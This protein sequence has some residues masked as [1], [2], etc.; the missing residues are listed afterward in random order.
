MTRRDKFHLLYAI[1]ILQIPINLTLYL[2]FE[3]HLCAYLA[4]YGGVPAVLIAV[5][6][7]LDP[8]RDKH[9]CIICGERH[10]TSRA[11][12]EC[13]YTHADSKMGGA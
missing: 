8:T 2:T 7:V 6:G 1:S 10:L 12:E 4:L 5:T 3:W 13:G 11:A 9:E